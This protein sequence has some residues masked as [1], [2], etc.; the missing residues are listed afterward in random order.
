RSGFIEPVFKLKYQDYED[1]W[2][3]SFIEDLYD[4]PDDEEWEYMVIKDEFGIP[5]EW[6]VD[7]PTPDWEQYIPAVDDWNQHR[8]ENKW[9]PFGKR[10]FPSAFQM[11]SG[12][13]GAPMLEFYGGS[14]AH[15]SIDWK[16]QNVVLPDGPLSAQEVQDAMELAPTP[17]SGNLN[18]FQANTGYTPPTIGN[19]QY[20]SPTLP[21]RIA[22]LDY[23]EWLSMRDFY[24]FRKHIHER[25]LDLL[26][27]PS[28]P[29]HNEYH[30]LIFVPIEY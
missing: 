7:R 16:G 30:D 13:F 15:G 1:Q 18:Q 27:S 22:V 8:H 24:L 17:P 25:N 3:E 19:Q 26:P 12:Y 20:A 21:K 28:D 11:M 5:I 10:D 29:K 9:Y 2:L 4:M 14:D 6:T 23:T